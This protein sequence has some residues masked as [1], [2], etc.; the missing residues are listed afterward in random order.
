M[1]LDRRNVDMVPWALVRHCR[2]LIIIITTII[3]YDTSGAQSRM[4]S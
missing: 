3:I 1:R 4:C 2:D